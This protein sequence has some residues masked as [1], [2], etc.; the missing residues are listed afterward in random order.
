MSARRRATRRADP[1]T[2]AQRAAVRGAGARGLALV[3]AGAGLVW[4][5]LVAALVLAV[6]RATVIDLFDDVAWG[7]GV[8]EW[9]EGIDLG[10]LVPVVLALVLLAVGAIALGCWLST[11]RM[12][13]AGMPRAAAITFRG[14]ALGTGLQAVLSTLSSWL[15]GL[16]VLLTGVV[17]FWLVAGVWLLLSMA[18]SALIGWLAGPRTWLAIARR[19]VAAAATDE[20]AA[21]TGRYL[22][23]AGDWHA[24]PD[25]ASRERLAELGIARVPALAA[26]YAQHDGQRGPSLGAVRLLP[27]AELRRIDDPRVGGSRDAEHPGTA[28][29]LARGTAR[30]PARGAEHAGDAVLVWQGRGEV[31]IGVHLSGPLSGHVFVLDAASQSLVPRWRS[32]VEFLDALLSAAQDGAV[33]ALDEESVPRSLPTTAPDAAH[34]ADDWALAQRLGATVRDR[35]DHRDEALLAAMALTP[36][37]QSQALE[38]YLDGADPELVVHAV[39]QLGARRWEPARARLTSLQQHPEQVVRDA[40]ERALRDWPAALAR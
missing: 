36:Y 10:A 15:L 9:I 3:G 21:V 11:R 35:D 6:L 28:L 33:D 7:R 32:V 14:A 39:E 8:I 2:T 40:V 22:A 5:L 17:G 13:A 23:A 25:P 31:G 4:G 29:E 19:E 12:Q 1:L 18:L 26:L 38:R 30:G 27:A 16:L 24:Q 20:A 37:A 34:D